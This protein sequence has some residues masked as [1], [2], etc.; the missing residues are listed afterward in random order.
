MA[1]I[2]I[3]GAGN[4]GS[5]L[6]RHWHSAGHSLAL[7]VNDPTSGTVRA[8]ADEVEAQVGTPADVA[9][10]VE[11]V[12][13]AIPG[14]AVLR[15]VEEL[16]AD[17]LDGRTLVVP[18]NDMAR[19]GGNLAADVARIAGGSLVVRAFNTISVETLTA[20][21]VNGE[22]VDM[23]Y[24]SHEPATALAEQLISDCGLHPVRIGD[25]ASGHLVDALFDLWLAL[26]YARRLG[27]GVVLALRGAAE[28]ADARSGTAG[29]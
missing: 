5:A 18:A 20:G 29:T 16:G 24:V 28:D 26:A 15:V 22:P 17:R 21:R 14:Q 3:I 19:R 11:V 2:G 8:L 25:L 7:G 6:A 23:F 9:A 27:R 1:N 10:T 4:I 12:T 13:L